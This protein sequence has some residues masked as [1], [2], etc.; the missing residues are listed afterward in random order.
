MKGSAIRRKSLESGSG[1]EVYE[2]QITQIE[3]GN[4]WPYSIV[5]KGPGKPLK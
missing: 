5:S 4:L 3:A 1:R 2:P